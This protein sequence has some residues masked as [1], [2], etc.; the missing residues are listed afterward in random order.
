[1]PQPWRAVSSAPLGGGIGARGW[2][3]NAQVPSAYDR[4]DVDAHLRS[5]AAEA[6]CAGSGVGFLTA[7]EV[8]RYNTAADGDVVVYATVGLRHPT[9]A[10]E[11][12]GES[13]DA[14]VGTINVVA[15]VR[16]HLSDA[17]LVNAVIT[18]TEA[19][20][21]AMTDQGFPG[22]GTASDAVC[23]LALPEGSVESFA[24]PRSRLGS[25]IAR[26]THGAVVDGA[27]EWREKW[28]RDR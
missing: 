11:P 27:I 15:F 16:A 26:A 9:W 21:Q 25:C 19:K 20:T 28:E 13:V 6:G 1:M 12:R 2:V 4:T 18:V 5:L 14:R 17:A 10:A 22:T 3:V 23:V 24:G 8:E 7:A